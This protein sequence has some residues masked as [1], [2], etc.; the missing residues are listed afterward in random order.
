MQNDLLENIL[1]SVPILGTST[2]GNIFWRP[3]VTS[4]SRPMSFNYRPNSKMYKSL[5]TAK[6]RKAWHLL[7]RAKSKRQNKKQIK[8]YYTH[9][10]EVAT[11]TLKN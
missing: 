5:Y 10:K 8:S 3:G 6:A 9:A 11:W 7:K 2:V 4:L 1:K